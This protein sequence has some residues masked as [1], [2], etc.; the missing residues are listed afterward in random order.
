MEPNNVLLRRSIPRDV[1]NI[2]L[3]V[4]KREKRDT[5]YLVQTKDNYYIDFVTLAATMPN[6]VEWAVILGEEVILNETRAFLAMWKNLAKNDATFLVYRSIIVGLV[7][8][9]ETVSMDMKRNL[10]LVLRNELGPNGSS[11]SPAMRIVCECHPK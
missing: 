3:A 7:G 10:S 6:Y 5:P 9:A 4:Q 2:A 1:Y 11:Y 8:G